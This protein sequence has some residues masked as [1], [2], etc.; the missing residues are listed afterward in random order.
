MLRLIILLI[1]IFAFCAGVFFL[2]RLLFTKN[3]PSEPVAIITVGSQTY[4]VEV[5]QTFEQK[6]KGLA[7]RDSLMPGR[8]MVFLFGAATKVA[9]TMHGMR[10]PLDMIWIADGKIIEISEGLQP[11]TSVLASSYRPKA[12]VDMVLE[13]NAGATKADGL[14]IGDSVILKYK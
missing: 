11:D 14:K 4:E 3:T 7:G 1:A 8:G 12:P 2:W 5:A 6:A 10:F 13:L 9:F